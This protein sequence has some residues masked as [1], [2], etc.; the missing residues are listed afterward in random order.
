[1]QPPNPIATLAALEVV[2][3]QLQHLVQTIAHLVQIQKSLPAGSARG[4]LLD[5][6]SCLDVILESMKRAVG[7]NDNPLDKY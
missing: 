3:N 4:Q 5:E 6:I 1:M 7:E 2:Q